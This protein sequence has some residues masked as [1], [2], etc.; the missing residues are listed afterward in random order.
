MSKRI[1]LTN[2]GKLDSDGSECRMIVGTAARAFAGT[3][4]ALARIIET[5]RPDQAIT[6]GALREG[7]S[8][9]VDVTT[10]KR[11]NQNP[12]SIA[13]AQGFI[14]YRPA[15]PAWAL[16]DFDTKGMPEEVKCHS[17]CNIDPLSRGIGLQN[18]L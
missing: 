6:L 14:D 9:S 5:C 7:I 15:C 18:W 10:K 4:S 3:A 12:G 2:D 13:R 8:T 11:L 17:A 1:S 16:I